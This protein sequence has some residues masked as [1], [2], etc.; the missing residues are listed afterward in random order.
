MHTTTTPLLT[1]DAARLLGISSEMVRFLARAGRLHPIRT[2][3]GVRIFD[4][5]EVLRLKAEREA[6]NAH[7]VA[8]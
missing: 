2:E 7:Q 5:D 3:S 6:A 1:G 8:V 4:R